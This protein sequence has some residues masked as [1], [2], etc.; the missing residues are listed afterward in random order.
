LFNISSSNDKLSRRIKEN[1]KKKYED[2]NPH[3]AYSDSQASSQMESKRSNR[4]KLTYSKAL[5]TS[6]DN[7]MKSDN[8]DKKY[9]RQLDIIYEDPY[10][11][12]KGIDPKQKEILDKYYIQDSSRRLR[13]SARRMLTPLM[14]PDNNIKFIDN[15]SLIKNPKGTKTPPPP[16]WGEDET[17]IDETSGEPFYDEVNDPNRDSRALMHLDSS[18]SRRKKFI[19][20][21]LKDQ[22]VDPQESETETVIIQSKRP[23][24]S[25]LK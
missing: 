9:A 10:D 16:L 15:G 18:R 1:F 14:T 23:K 8:R 22:K 20:E 13:P 2:Y 12:K 5:R 21:F 25:K 4:G 24:G 19:S 6:G 11:E 3:S 17:E 7:V